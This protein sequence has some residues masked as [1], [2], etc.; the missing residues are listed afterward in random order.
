MLQ[1]GL[2]LSHLD[3][4]L[5]FKNHSIRYDTCVAIKKEV[6]NFDRWGLLRVL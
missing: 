1:K 5:T 6:N 2:D 3:P 4:L